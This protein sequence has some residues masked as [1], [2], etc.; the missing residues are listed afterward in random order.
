M[1]YA[2]VAAQH[3]P[4]NE[5]KPDPALLNTESVSADAIADD[6]SKVNVVPSDFK[7]HP[8]TVTS[9]TEIIVD[10]EEPAP[11]V[12]RKDKAKDK[13]KKRLHQAEVE[14]VYLWEVAK[15]YLFRPGVAGGLLGVVNVGLISGV[16]YLYY[17][18]PH[19]RRDTKV[20]SS[21][22]AGAVA[23]LG[24]Q[25]WG[26]ETYRRTPKGQEEERKARAEGAVIYRH[27]RENILRPGVLGGIVGLLNVG[28]LGTVGYFGYTNWDKPTWDRRIVSSVSVGLLALW[29]GEGYFA[30]QYR[31]S[32]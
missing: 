9:E 6:T 31:K 13:A 24:L 19:L 29:G 16:G 7:Q 22:V 11:P 4:P 25:G 2:S 21:T 27:L 5:P 14:G 32:H 18:K 17:T 26:A 20:L 1:S 3:L 15:E 28:I 23:L 10:S 8:H 12:P 30:E